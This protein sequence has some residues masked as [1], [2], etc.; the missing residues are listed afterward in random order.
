MDQKSM[1][2]QM[3]RQMG[4]MAETLDEAVRKV[5]GVGRLVPGLYPPVDIYESP[6]E[7]IVRAD[8]PGPPREELDVS[9]LNRTL[10]IRGRAEPEQYEDLTCHRKERPEGDFRREIDLPAAVDE[11]VDVTAVLQNGV[12]TVRLKKQ[13][14]EQGRRIE[15]QSE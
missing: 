5:P 4:E 3:R 12:L 7:L 8:V 11:D 14:P 9:L 2:R 15:V 10:T 1:W 6:E 13:L